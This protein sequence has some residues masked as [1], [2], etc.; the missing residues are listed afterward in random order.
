MEEHKYLR[1]S[2]LVLSLIVLYF[3]YRIFQPF[4][5]PIS[6]A[7]VLAT[8]CFPVFDWTCEKLQNRRNWAALL[9]C[10]WVTA[11]IIVPFVVLIILLAG[12][13]TEV[14][15]QFQSGLESESWQEFLNLQ[16]NPYLKPFVDW[17]GQYVDLESLDLMGSLGTGLQQVSLFFLRQS[18]SIVSGIFRLLMNI[19]C[20]P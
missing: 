10:I 18:T 7:V 19:R 13:M 1:N 8:L 3:V 12:Q 16:D 14:Y 6:L 17:I 2:L 11:S 5:L 9:T 20:R 4:L 15:R